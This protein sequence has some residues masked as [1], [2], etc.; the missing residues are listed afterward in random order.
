MI[1]KVDANQ[2]LSTYFIYANISEYANK[3]QNKK[4]KIYY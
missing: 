3:V 2:L 4:D 1:V